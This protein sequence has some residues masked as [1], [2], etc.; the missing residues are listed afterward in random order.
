MK[1]YIGS[2]HAGYE[3]KKEIKNYLLKLGYEVN[4]KG[5]FALNNDDDYPDYTNMV[6]RAVS[7]NDGSM[8]IIIG[9]S[10]EGEA[11]CANRLKGIRATVYY[12]GKG[13]QK[14]IFGNKIGLIASTRIH[15]NANILSLGARFLN[16]RKAR[17]AVKIF[18]ETPFSGDERHIRRINKID[19]I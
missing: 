2:D 17:K 3:L 4:D 12:G 5:P 19:N 6:A 11:M 16:K 15:N 10:G 1:I 8:G 7:E 9:G 14:D 18:I 13:V